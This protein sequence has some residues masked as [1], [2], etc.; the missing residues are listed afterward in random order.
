MKNWSPAKNWFKR[1]RCGDVWF[2]FPLKNNQSNSLLYLCGLVGLVQCL[3]P[4]WDCFSKSLIPISCVLLPELVLRIATMSASKAPH[5]QIFPLGKVFSGLCSNELCYHFV[6]QSNFWE[7]LPTQCMLCP[8]KV[9]WHKGFL[10]RKH[11]SS[12]PKEFPCDSRDWPRPASAVTCLQ[13]FPVRPLSLPDRSNA[14]L[15]GKTEFLAV[16]YFRQWWQLRYTQRVSFH[17][18]YTIQND[19]YF[20][21]VLAPSVCSS[22]LTWVS[23]LALLPFYHPWVGCSWDRSVFWACQSALIVCGFITDIKIIWFFCFPLF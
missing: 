9:L 11:I 22:S 6:E 1:F 18:L 14:R 3:R 7:C 19:V 10:Q 17:P 13:L 23:S 15:S 12:F 8:V 5:P 2:F 20:W 21:P 16:F 4:I